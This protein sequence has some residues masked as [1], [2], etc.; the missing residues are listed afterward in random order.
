MV[1]EIFLPNSGILL[2]STY[3]YRNVMG[4]VFPLNILHVVTE[5]EEVSTRLFLICRYGRYSWSFNS[6]FD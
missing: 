1:K 6:V 4:E 2:C 5:R 3:I